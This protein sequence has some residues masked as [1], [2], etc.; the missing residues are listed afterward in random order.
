MGRPAAL[1][2][3]IGRSRVSGLPQTPANLLLTRRGARGA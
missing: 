1:E 3:T 2:I